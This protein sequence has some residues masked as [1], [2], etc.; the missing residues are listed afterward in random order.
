MLF[1]VMW[2]SFHIH[3]R[4]NIG[5]ILSTNIN[6][7]NTMKQSHDRNNRYILEP[8]TGAQDIL[9][10]LLSDCQELSNGYHKSF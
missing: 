4:V 6:I 9:S 8:E 5:V 2:S 10:R 7:L 1:R 3:R